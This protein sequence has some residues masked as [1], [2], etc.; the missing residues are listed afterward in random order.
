MQARRG[1]GSSP[2]AAPKTE[3]APAVHEQVASSYQK[4][5]QLVSQA[6]EVFEGTS[7]LGEL[8]DDPEARAPA[9]TPPRP[10]SGTPATSPR[11]RRDLAATSQAAAVEYSVMHRADPEIDAKTALVREMGKLARSAAC[12]LGGSR[13]S[14]SDLAS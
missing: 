2:P 13:T 5:Y 4:V 12:L 14:Q 9:P 8:A 1:L 7:K 6:R 10:P 11:P 3:V